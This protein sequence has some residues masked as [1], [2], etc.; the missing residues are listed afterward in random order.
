ME[1]IVSK[2]LIVDDQPCVRQ[3]VA[4]ELILEGYQVNSAGDVESARERISFF[5]P[6]L[7]ILDFCVDGLEGFDLLEEIKGQSPGLP[8]I[9]FTAYDSFR[10]DPRL[11]EADGYVIKSLDLSGLKQNVAS[12][13][14]VKT[15]KGITVEDPLP[16]AN[17]A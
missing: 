15:A 16:F 9:I 14:G 13:F 17:I 4:A 1:D 10:A 8:I 7:V 5:E 2:I 11:S 3:L 12:V 6:D